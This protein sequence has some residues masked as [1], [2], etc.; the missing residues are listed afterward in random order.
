MPGFFPPIS[1]ICI[2]L[3][4]SWLNIG[5]CSRK[6]NDSQTSTATTTTTTVVANICPKMD[7]NTFALWFV[8]AHCDDDED[9]RLFPE[10][11]EFFS[12]CAFATRTFSFYTFYILCKFVNFRGKCERKWKRQQQHWQ[13]F[14]FLDILMEPFVECEH[15]A[16][17][18]LR[19]LHILYRYSIFLLQFT[20]ANRVGSVFGLPQSQLRFENI[21]FQDTLTWH[22][23]LTLCHSFGNL[24]LA[25]SFSEYSLPFCCLNKSS[26]APK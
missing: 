5:A 23:F 9:V 2:M 15:E 21:S 10:F 14:L 16:I 6:W 1:I 22:H 4:Y 12:F 11:A 24:S 17:L 20:V 7:V 3:I 26:C 8:C 19:I 13:L 25:S 18:M